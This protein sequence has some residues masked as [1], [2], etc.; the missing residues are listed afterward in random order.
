MKI[1]GSGLKIVAAAPLSAGEC[2]DCEKEELA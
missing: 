2:E 1:Q